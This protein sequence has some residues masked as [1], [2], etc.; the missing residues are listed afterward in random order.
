[1]PNKELEDALE[2]VTDEYI[3]GLLRQAQDLAQERGIFRRRRK[4]HSYY[5]LEAALKLAIVVWK[6]EGER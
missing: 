4:Y 3:A 5:T 6:A 2:N 1:M